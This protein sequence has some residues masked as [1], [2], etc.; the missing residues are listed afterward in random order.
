M[1]IRSIFILLITSAVA[2]LSQT[3]TVNI[4]GFVTDEL[5]GKPVGKEMD[6]IATSKNT[7]KKLTVKVN[8][9]T[10]EY[11]QPMTSGDT[12]TL[13]FTSYAVYKKTEVLD[14][15]PTNKYREEKHDYK[16]RSIIQGSEIVNLN[17]FD[18]GQSTI[19]PEATQKLHETID[20]L[21][22]NKELNVVVKILQEQ[23]P[24]PPPVPAKKAVKSKPAKGKK[25]KEEVVE[26]PPVVQYG[27]INTSLYDARIQSFKNLFADVKNWEIR[28]KFEPGESMAPAKGQKNVVVLV[29][30]VKSIMD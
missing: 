27:A 1:I 23:N 10:G 16:V 2:G 14:I 28:V 20:V 13:T 18:V 24:P 8:S 11:L 21:K 22:Q 19:S 29:G 12:Y 6:I 5:T 4:K 9:K 7:G 17:A 3:A 25:Q 26:A 30:E 15:P